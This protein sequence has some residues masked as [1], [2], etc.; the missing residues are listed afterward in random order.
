MR[1]FFLFGLSSLAF[2]AMGFVAREKALSNKTNEKF[3][4]FLSS[5]DEKQREDYLQ[6]VKSGIQ[7]CERFF[8]ASFKNEFN[9]IVHPSRKSMDSTWQV[10][11]KMPDFKSECWMVASGVANKLD[12]LSLQKWSTESCEHNA[13]D[14]S[15]VSNLIAH[16]IIH[17]YHGQIHPTP[18]FSQAEGI[19]WLVEGLAT[20][21]SGQYDEKRK[22]DLLKHY[23]NNALPNSLDNFWKGKMKYGLSGSMIAFIDKKYGRKKLIDLC[24]LEK[25]ADVLKSLNTNEEILIKEWKLALGL[26]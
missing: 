12:L 6:Y 20:Y 22:S 5:T 26:K 2:L 19:D 1:R 8:T 16:E 10:E 21:A 24:R 9:V 14:K 4:I 17:V 18:D 25:K 15:A 23:E 11:W 13:E 7:N 3:K